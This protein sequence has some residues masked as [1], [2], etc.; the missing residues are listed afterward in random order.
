MNEAHFGPVA[1]RGDVERD[2]GAGPL[3]RVL[4]E[5]EAGVDHPPHDP[6]SRNQLSDLLNGVV[7]VPV[8]VRELIS[9]FVGVAFDVACP[10]STNI[11]Y[12]G[13]DLVGRPVDGERSGETVTGH[14]FL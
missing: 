1:L 4:G 12:S 11:C 6:P 2:V 7:E 13:E 9:D 14:G 3:A 8:A 5:R 10:P